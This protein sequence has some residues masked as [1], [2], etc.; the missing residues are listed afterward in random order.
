MMVNDKALPSDNEKPDEEQHK[1]DPI[2]LQ[3]NK[4]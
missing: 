1:S 4:V 2:R 3:L